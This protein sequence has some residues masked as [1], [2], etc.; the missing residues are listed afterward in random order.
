MDFRGSLSNYEINFDNL[1]AR[2]SA[3]TQQKSD[4]LTHCAILASYRV[5]NF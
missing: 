4:H 1:S 3:R 5:Q 2:T